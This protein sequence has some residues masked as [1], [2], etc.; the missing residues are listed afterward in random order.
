MLLGALRTLF[1]ILNDCGDD[2]SAPAWR[3]CFSTII[4]QILVANQR[5]YE[6]C[7]TDNDVKLADTGA[8][9]QSEWNKTAIILVEGMASVMSTNLNTMNGDR[10]FSETWRELLQCLRS[11]LARSVLDLSNAIFSGLVS[12]LEEI[13][14]LRAVSKSSIN[15]TWTLWKQSN[16][17]FHASVSDTTPNNQDALLAYL[18][19]LAQIFRLK[20]TDSRIEGADAVLEELRSCVVN[21]D[22]GAY[23]TDV[24]RVTPV[25]H[26]ILENLKMIPTTSGA[27]LSQIVLF[28]TFLVALPYSDKRTKEKGQTHLAMSNLAIGVLQ[29]LVNNH[30]K[31]VDSPYELVTQALGALATPICLKY[32][33]YVEST[34]PSTWRTATTA[35]LKLLENCLPALLREQESEEFREAFWEQVVRI[36]DGIVAADVES[37]RPGTNILDD[38]EFDLNAFAWIRQLVIPFLGS[39]SIS[40]FRR[41]EFA[42]II[43]EKSLIH[44]PHPDDLARPD[45][46]LLD[47]LKNQHIGRT[48][49]LPPTPRVKM[50]Y[51]L[52]DE[53]FSLV[54]VHDGS[55][56][57]VRLSQA[58]APYLIL[59][60]GLTLRA[61]VLDHPLRGLAPQP[62]SQKLEMFHVLEKLVE[63]KCEPE[64]MHN[65]TSVISLHKKPLYYL[66]PL[67]TKA[68]KVAHRDA[69]MTG[70]LGN[71]LEAVG[72]DFGI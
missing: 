24:S 54:A 16:P 39:S 13:E 50:S 65:V 14:D 5:K 63:L 69:E 33:W 59:R 21:A 48:D 4:R 49:D 6:Q 12:I 27:A 72:Q 23:S 66:Y 42:R 34:T 64:A 60:A 38:Q 36:T 17:V 51:V 2:L 47:G 18:R 70:A 25:Q 31:V 44:E 67:V 1:R 58:V 56:E 10:T 61:Y 40:D 30:I 37:C 20:D 41:T 15:E 43:F 32:K 71:V 46:E 68:M 26:G 52:L 57:R 11:F 35:A 9:L 45:Q 62:Y 19:C 28:V 8:S 53:L 3:V 22:L 55:P 7:A 29:G